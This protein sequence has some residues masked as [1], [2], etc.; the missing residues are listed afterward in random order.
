MCIA[1][2]ETLLT[3][4]IYV[5]L[6]AF[7]MKDNR[8]AVSINS[9]MHTPLTQLFHFSEGTLGKY[10]HENVHPRMVTAAQFLIPGAWGEQPSCP[11]VGNQ[12]NTVGKS[13]KEEGK[14]LRHI[15]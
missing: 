2:H 3:S 12:P 14:P 6:T 10:G 11:P 5:L 9:N 4:N 15:K 7:I 1:R 8:L 13:E